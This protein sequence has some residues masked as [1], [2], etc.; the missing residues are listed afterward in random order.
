MDNSEI[1]RKNIIL[2]A[3]K[4]ITFDSGTGIFFGQKAKSFNKISLNNIYL[5]GKIDLRNVELMGTMN[6]K[7]QTSIFNTLDEEMLNSKSSK[8][9]SDQYG[10]VY[11]PVYGDVLGTINSKGVLIGGD[12]GGYIGSTYK[13][14]FDETTQSHFNPVNILNLD[15]FEKLESIPMNIT[16]FDND[17]K[18]FNVYSYNI[19][20]IRNEPDYIDPYFGNLFNLTLNGLDDNINSIS[21]LLYTDKLSS[22]MTFNSDADLNI[23][24]NVKLLNTNTTLTFKNVNVNN[25]S[26][27]VLNNIEYINGNVRIDGNYI[28]NSFANLEVSQIYYY[29]PDLTGNF[30]FNYNSNMIEEP[31]NIKGNITKYSFLNIINWD[32]YDVNDVKN[33]PIDFPKLIETTPRFSNIGD[34]NI[35]EYA[36]TLM[37]NTN[38]YY[39]T[40]L[41]YGNLTA[42]L[43]SR[44]SIY[45]N[46]EGTLHRI[47]RENKDNTIQFNFKSYYG[48]LEYNNNF[49]LQG[50]IFNNGNPSVLEYLDTI[51]DNIG[52]NDYKSLLNNIDT[53]VRYKIPYIYEYYDWHKQY[54]FTN[55]F[56][57]D[58]Y[59]GLSN[60]DI[61]KKSWQIYGNINIDSVNCWY[62]QSGISQNEDYE[63]SENP[64]NQGVNDNEA[65]YLFLG[66][67]DNNSD[68]LFNIESEFKFNVSGYAEYGYDGL[69]VCYLDYNSEDYD[70]I[71]EQ[72]CYNIKPQN[73]WNNLPSDSNLNDIVYLT[74]DTIFQI[75]ENISQFT[76]LTYTLPKLEN[77]LKRYIVIMYSKDSYFSKAPDVFRLSN[78][79]IIP[80]QNSLTYKYIDY[81]WNLKD[82]ITLIS[83]FNYLDLYSDN[84]LYLSTGNDTITLP[85]NTSTYFLIGP[86][87]YRDFNIKYLYKVFLE[88]E[89]GTINFNSNSRIELYQVETDTEIDPT[90]FTHEILTDNVNNIIKTFE[91]VGNKIIYQ[92]VR[93]YIVYNGLNDDKYKYFYF[94]VVTNN[95]NAGMVIFNLKF[96]QYVQADTNIQTDT[97]ISINLK[98]R[99][100]IAKVQP[101][102][103]DPFDLVYNFTREK[104]TL[105]NENALDISGE[106]EE[107][108]LLSFNAFLSNINGN[109]KG[110]IFINGDNTYN[111]TELLGTFIN[112]NLQLGTYA[113]NNK[114]NFYNKDYY[115]YTWHSNLEYLNIINLPINPTTD[116][117]NPFDGLKYKNIMLCGKM[118]IY[119]IDGTYTNTPLHDNQVGILEYT[120]I[121]DNILKKN[122]TINFKYQMFSEFRG[123]YFYF[124]YSIDNGKNYCDLLKQSGDF[125][126]LQSVALLDNFRWKSVSFYLPYNP[127]YKFRWVYLKDSNLSSGY[128]TVFLGDIYVN[129]LYSVI[130]NKNEKLNIYADNFIGN[131]SSGVSQNTNIKNFLL[132]FLKENTTLSYGYLD[133]DIM[134]NG[135]MDNY[136]EPTINANSN[137]IYANIHTFYR[138][139]TDYDYNEFNTYN[140]TSIN[141]INVDKSW[142][143]YTY[144]TLKSKLSGIWDALSFNASPAFLNNSELAILSSQSKKNDNYTAGLNNNDAA[145]FTIGP[146]DYSDMMNNDHQLKF[147]YYINAD[148]NWDSLGVIM[149]D[150]SPVTNVTD[151][152]ILNLLVQI[153]D[154]Y[155][156][157]D[158]YNLDALINKYDIYSILI[159]DKI[160]SYP[161]SKLGFSKTYG[162]TLG[163]N[164]VL[165][166]LT[167]I[168]VNNK[169]IIVFFYV[170]DYWSDYYYDDIVL[171]HDIQF[172]FT[173]SV[174]SFR[175][176][177][178][179]DNKLII[180]IPII[181]KKQ[182]LLKN[183]DSDSPSVSTTL[184]TNIT[185]S[186]VYVLSY[187]TS[188]G[189]SPITERGVCYQLNNDYEL[190]T[191]KSKS[192]STQNADVFSTKI[193]NLTAGSTYY[194]R[195]YAINSF[196]TSY[197]DSEHFTS[198]VEFD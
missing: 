120:F 88:F 6:T 39:N 85:E 187:I 11:G 198:S 13:E 107:N 14:V 100:M 176:S 190:T 134:I 22:V 144:N 4:S 93:E 83:E 105:D 110:N 87:S 189:S 20:S 122:F 38:D 168:P 2:S 25:I 44:M 17:L 49:N 102:F 158:H 132:P 68:L 131:I 193:I 35:I 40:Q 196:G 178:I 108:P 32:T 164:D 106:I 8:A 84:N 63:Y 175:L 186:S 163:W 126:N 161:D 137:L 42:N 118:S 172:T 50:N 143:L 115:I 34:T 155:G 92:S 57:N 10:P 138:K 183:I 121:A 165:I 64:Y 54:A 79:R 47:T 157:Y 109:L 89:Y 191:N 56:S 151:N 148:S 28:N 129:Y 37:N 146:L 27:S 16:G 55:N 173:Q 182:I 159:K 46:I 116:I 58:D 78:F 1:Y 167:K 123:D 101:S 71:K 103:M 184:I 111:Q 141:D 74:Y 86:I 26:N 145:I 113:F 59:H 73:T 149:Y 96:N 90:D 67:F 192:V 24:G 135:T 197:G 3:E 29:E 36:D 70:N 150:Y 174:S 62:F 95:T 15:T 69:T 66:L 31:I 180:D 124:Q 114:L 5:D 188:N 91:I 166:E 136:I 80:T 171:I 7:L 179:N 119:N 51:Q 30:Q 81:S 18:N 72:L 162:T 140:I 139:T 104:L 160:K 127:I 53:W 76:E 194:V 52:Y 154:L 60:D 19:S 97:D 21:N 125:N 128:D 61:R 48:N 43:Y 65:T 45:S 112:G 117:S 133:G 98:T 147:K 12:R 130:E 170:K 82:K 153:V 177:K 185:S 156:I 77:G 94:K 181:G 33:A 9:L 99:K 142:R 41:L 195:S 152:E 23:E 75:D 169:R